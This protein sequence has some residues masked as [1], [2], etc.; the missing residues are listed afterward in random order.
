MRILLDQ[1]DAEGHFLC[2]KIESSGFEA[3]IFSLCR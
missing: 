3:S 1:L 2:N